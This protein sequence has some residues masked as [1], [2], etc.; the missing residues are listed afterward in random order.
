MNID[1]QVLRWVLEHRSDALTAAFRAVTVLGT[2]GVVVFVVAGC[3][4]L[5]ASRRRPDLAL[6]LVVSAAGTWLTVNALKLSIRRPRPPEVVRL[7]HASGWSFPSGHAG[8]ATATWLALGIVVGLVATRRWQK[9]TSIA[10]GAVLALLVGVSRVYLGVHWMTDVLVG[11]LVG[12][13][14]FVTAFLV[15]TRRRSP[16]GRPE[17]RNHPVG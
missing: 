1:Q 8:Q 5:L 6:A 9:A 17:D 14:W 16:V 4:A 10:V 12:V 15:A 11:W 7:V 13:A 2:V 3:A